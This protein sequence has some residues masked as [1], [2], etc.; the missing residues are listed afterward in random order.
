MWILHTVTCV[1]CAYTLNEVHNLSKEMPSFEKNKECSCKYNFAMHFV[2]K[3]QGDK[4]YTFIKKDIS[5]LHNFV[6][7]LTDIILLCS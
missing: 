7:L 1:L 3:E 6:G 2:I 4:R 5:Q